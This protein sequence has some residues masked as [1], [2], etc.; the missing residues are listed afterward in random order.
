MFHFVFV[1]VLL[2]SN[3]ESKP[4]AV[5]KKNI[6]DF[7]LNL[8]KSIVGTTPNDNVFFSPFSI[9]LA[10][11]M[12]ASG[13]RGK[14]EKELLNLLQI[15]SRDKLDASVKQLMNITHLPEIKLANRLY[16]DEKFSILPAF[17]QRLQKLYNISLVSVNLNAKNVTSVINDINA[18]VY[19]R[20]NG[21]I[22]EALNKNDLDTNRSSTMNALLII[23]CLLFDGTFFFFSYIFSLEYF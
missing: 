4:T 19:N 5:S 18:W 9:S 14:T 17:K 7:H 11:S 20:T 8:Y 13:A 10:L 6:E 16:P 21:H 2:L 15:P 12:V 22:K 1:V 23:N 3:A